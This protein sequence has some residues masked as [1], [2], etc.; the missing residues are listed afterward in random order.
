MRELGFLS[1][2]SSL[3]F[4][5]YLLK[6]SSDGYPCHLP[7]LGSG[8]TFNCGNLP[9]KVKEI[10][11][12]LSSASYVF[13]RLIGAVVMSLCVKDIQ[14]LPCLADLLIQSFSRAKVCHDISLTICCLEDHGFVSHQKS[15]LVLT[16]LTFYLRGGQS[17]ILL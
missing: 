11:F 9:W 16:Q 12:V 5:G 13:T 4:Q 3:P 1:E 14:I 6:N 17:Y 15:N 10:P 8:L 7:G 2:G